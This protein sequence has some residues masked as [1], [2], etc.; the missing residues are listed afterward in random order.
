MENSSSGT[1]TP[2]PEQ[3]H[4]LLPLQATIQQIGKTVERKR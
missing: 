4:A 2:T 3:T 1:P